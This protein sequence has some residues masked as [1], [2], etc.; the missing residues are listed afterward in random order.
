MKFWMPR[1]HV[2]Y[3]HKNILIYLKY[4]FFLLLQET[5][6]LAR[7]IHIFI[8]RYN[9]TWKKK[10]EA[11]SSPREE[12]KSFCAIGAAQSDSERKP[13]AALG[14]ILHLVTG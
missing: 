10:F 3:S 12:N 13:A 4:R 6:Y 8:S 5:N 2:D 14:A 1:M 11:R 7:K 9:I